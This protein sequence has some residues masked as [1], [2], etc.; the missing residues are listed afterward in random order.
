ME[1]FLWKGQQTDYAGPG[2][3]DT[4]FPAPLNRRFLERLTGPLTLRD[5]GR[6]RVMEIT[7]GDA[8]NVTVQL[9]DSNSGQSHAVCRLH[10]DSSCVLFRVD[11]T[12]QLACTLGELFA[13][14]PYDKTGKAV[15]PVLD[16]SRYF[17]LKVVD[18][19]SGKHAYLGMGFQERTEAFDFQV[20]LQDW[21]K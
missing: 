16:S 3:L 13:Q 9:E 12:K 2:N 7:S 10:T 6:C 4:T 8:S 11:L 18:V 14:C 15:E 5:T 19:A 20:A 21:Q 1:A 17:V